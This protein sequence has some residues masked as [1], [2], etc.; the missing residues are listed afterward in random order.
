MGKAKLQELNLTSIKELQTFLLTN[1]GKN[2]SG[3]VHRTIRR[4]ET[5][6]KN[7][8]QHAVDDRLI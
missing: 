3:I 5:W 1:A 4:V 8:L 2:K 7:V 6:M